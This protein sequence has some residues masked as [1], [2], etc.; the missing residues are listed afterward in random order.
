MAGNS[1]AIVA[2]LTAAALATVAFLGHQAASNASAHPRAT[3]AGTAPGGVQADRGTEDA[4]GTHDA[5]TLTAPPRGSGQGARVVYAL[6]TD[7]VWLV[8]KSGKV[9]RTFT[10]KPGTVDPEP[11]T[12]R[13]TS[14][15]GKVTGSDGVPVEHVVRF[16]D[17]DGT[18][19]GFSAAVD[20]SVPELDPKVR[21][22]G[23][24][25]TR[26]DGRAM[27]KFATIGRKVVVVR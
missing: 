23:V 11:G 21:T 9:E 19:I 3:R 4:D 7:Q 22:G 27:W 14:R 5:G 6:D 20:G 8:E 24:R 16:A 12:Y 1:S 15:S 26:A 17:I 25:E 13:V 18:V 2:G 10:V